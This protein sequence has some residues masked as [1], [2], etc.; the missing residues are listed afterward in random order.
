MRRCPLAA[1]RFVFAL[2]RLRALPRDPIPSLR[3]RDV[4]AHDTNARL[5][6]IDAQERVAR[7]VDSRPRESVLAQLRLRLRS[8]IANRRVRRI[9]ICAS[10]NPRVPLE[11]YSPLAA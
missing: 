6:A 1:P 10:V 5:R 4:F 2:N 3:A 9:F 7:R 11:G 8:A